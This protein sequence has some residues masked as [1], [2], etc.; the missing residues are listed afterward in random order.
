MSALFSRG[1]HRIRVTY[2]QGPGYAVALVLAISPPHAPY[3]IFHT[4]DFLPPKD[5]AMWVAGTISDIERLKFP[6]MP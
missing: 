1:T 2:Y 5:P 3:K 4:D 6:G